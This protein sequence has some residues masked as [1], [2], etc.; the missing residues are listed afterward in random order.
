VAKSLGNK[1]LPR[2]LRNQ[3]V[4]APAII[5]ILFIAITGILITSYPTY[6]VSIIVGALILSTASMFILTNTIKQTFLTTIDEISL[7]A[8]QISSGKSVDQ[9]FR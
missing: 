3:P 4:L 6:I 2:V 1:I 9:E 5:N 8:K 7:F